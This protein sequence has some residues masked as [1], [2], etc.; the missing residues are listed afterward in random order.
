MQVNFNDLSERER[1]KLLTSTVVPR[2]IALVT[3]VDANG[4]ANAAPFSFFNCMSSTPP[5][6]VIGFENRGTGNIKD[7]L[8]NIRTTGQFVV[9]LVDEPLGEAMNI[10]ATDFAPEIDEIAESGVGTTASAMIKPPR[11]VDAPVAFECRTFQTVDLGS[12]RAI[13]IGEVLCMHIRDRVLDVERMRVDTPALGLIARLQNP[14]WYSRTTDLFQI[15]RLH[16]DDWPTI[17][18]GRNTGEK[19][20]PGAGHS[21][22]KRI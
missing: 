3:T 5:L 6:L 20:H 13:E 10:M 4:V 19:A 22:S 8:A 14:G 21:P 12:G 1:S 2:P 9:H 15:R 18:A 11:I 16:P 17:K 7:T